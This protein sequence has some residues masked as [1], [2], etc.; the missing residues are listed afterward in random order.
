MKQ[1]ERDAQPE[2]RELVKTVTAELVVKR[3]RF[4][5]RLE[6]VFDRPAVERALD[7]RRAMHPDAGHVVYAFLLGPTRSED[8]G[9]SDAGEPRG[10]AGRPIM[11]IL[12]GNSVRNCLL[13]VVRYFGGTKLG[14]GGLVK[15]YGDTAR[16]L[17]GAAQTRPL[18]E[19]CLVEIRIAYRFLDA[20]MPRIAARGGRV[21]EQVFGE[22][23]V[24]TMEIPVIQA[25]ELVAAVTEGT[26]GS[27]VITRDAGCP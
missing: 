15:A 14:T 5:G 4:L 16:A 3:S 2:D 21:V 23:V 6:P 22:E 11:D 26:S 17:I 9:V 12:R 24:L 8:A 13:T 19:R 18:L 20:L 1:S 25:E 10:T 27:A 7:N